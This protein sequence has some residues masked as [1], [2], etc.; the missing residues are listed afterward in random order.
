[1]IYLLIFPILFFLAFFLVP[2]GYNLHELTHLP[3]FWQEMYRSPTEEIQMQKFYYGKHSRQY[4]IQMQHPNWPIN[5]EHV[6]IYAHGGGWQFGRPE[7]FKPNA[8][9]FLKNGFRTYII[10]HRKLPIFN[11]HD[12][13]S[14]IQTAVSSIKEMHPEENIK[15]ILGGVSSGGHL[16]ASLINQKASIRQHIAGVFLLAAPLNLSKMR[17]SIVI[18]QLAGKPGTNYYQE[19]NP[20]ENITNQ[21]NLPHLIVQGEKDGLVNFLSTLSYVERFQGLNPSQLTFHIIPNGTHLDAV[22]WGFRQDEVGTTLINW[23]DEIS[24]RS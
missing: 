21:I 8:Q 12:M 3:F 2:K 24:S 16:V 7:A 17:Q 13:L 18:N 5:K 20:F 10:G 22:K 6:I 15:I 4:Y 14:D 19:V 11:F 9:F 1:M 23:L